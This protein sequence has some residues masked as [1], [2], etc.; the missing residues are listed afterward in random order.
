[1][2]DSFLLFL[3]RNPPA[4]LLSSPGCLHLKHTQEELTASP[5]PDCSPPRV[6]QLCP[7]LAWAPILAVLPCLRPALSTSGHPCPQHRRPTPSASPAWRPFR[8]GSRTA[9]C[10]ASLLRRPAPPRQPGNLSPAAG[11]PLASPERRPSSPCPA[12]LSI[13]LTFPRTLPASSCLRQAVGSKAPHRSSPGFGGAD[14]PALEDPPFALFPLFVA[15]FF[16][17]PLFLPSH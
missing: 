2:T 3:I 8:W 4:N 13:L 9:S 16:P 17:D 15:S 12:G 5:P 6:P 14:P 10:S 1:M 7:S 11:S